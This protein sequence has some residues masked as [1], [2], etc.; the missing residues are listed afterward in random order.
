MLPYQS[1][2]LVAEIL[3]ILESSFILLGNKKFIQTKTGPTWMPQAR[4]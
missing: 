4:P 1:E 3:L 2:E